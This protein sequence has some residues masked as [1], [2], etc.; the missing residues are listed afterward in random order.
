MQDETIKSYN[1]NYETYL[2]KATKVGSEEYL[3]MLDF[4]VEN[5]SCS[6]KVLEIGSGSLRDAKYLREKGVKVFCTDVADRAISLAKENGFEVEY[7]DFRN[8]PKEEWLGG[9][10]GVF[11]SAVLLHADEGQFENAIK[12]I[13]SILKDHGVFFLALKGGTGEYV[14]EEKLG[15]KRYFKLW[16][17]DNVLKITADN[18]LKL[19][20]FSQLEDASWIYFVFG[21]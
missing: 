17:K 20:K 15:G 12:N 2:A 10:N 21:K 1:E 7:F 9:F 3:E 4:F 5:I 16:E 19:L 6:K 18:N 8:N 13:S 11:C 14:D